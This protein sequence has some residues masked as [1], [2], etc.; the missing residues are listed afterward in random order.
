MAKRKEETWLHPIHKRSGKPNKI[1]DYY[2]ENGNLDTLPI[3]IMISS[4]IGPE[5]LLSTLQWLESRLVFK[6]QSSILP[7]SNPTVHPLNIIQVGKNSVNV[8]CINT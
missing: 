4:H 8:Q 1:K 3:G 5:I 6:L 7:L 2:Q